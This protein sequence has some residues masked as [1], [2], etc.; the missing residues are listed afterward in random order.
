M[1]GS[2]TVYLTIIAII[3]ETIGFQNGTGAALTSAIQTTANTQQSVD[4]ITKSGPVKGEKLVTAIEGRTYYS[5]KGIPYAQPPIGPL[6]FLPP[7][8]TLPWTEPKIANQFGKACVQYDDSLKIIG[9]EN[10]LFLNVYVPSKKDNL[11]DR[12]VLVY[13]HG[14]NW[15]AGSGDDKFYGPDFLI[16]HGVILVTLN[17]R[18]GPMGFLSLGLGNYSGNQGLKDQQ[19]AVK[20][21]NENIAAFGGDPAK[22]TIFGHGTGSMSCE[23]HRFSPKSKGLFYQTIEMSGAWNYG[24]LFQSNNQLIPLTQVA[25]NNKQMDVISYLKTVDLSTL[26]TH[27]PPTSSR[28]INKVWGPVIEA[29]DDDQPFIWSTPTEQLLQPDFTSNVNI[30]TGFTSLEGLFV[31]DA[32]LLDPLSFIDPSAK[33]YIPFP[34]ENF[35]EFSTQTQRYDEAEIEIRQHYYPN[36]V[37]PTQKTVEANLKLISNVFQ[38]Y[39][40]D[41]RIKITAQQSNGNIFLYRFG[42]D[43]KFNYFKNLLGSSKNIPAGASHGDELCYTFKCNI[44]P[45]MYSDVKL[46]TPENGLL[47]VMPFFISN[48]ARFSNPNP[49]LYPNFQPCSSPDMQ[50]LDITNDGVEFVKQSP[51]NS[52]TEFWRKLMLKYSDLVNHNINV[53]LENVV[54]DILKVWA[55]DGT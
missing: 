22:I 3:G 45:D 32:K 44:V 51:W 24:K 21:V 20:W 48:F 11:P 29:A 38:N 16:N 37:T 28:A 7:L 49:I 10:C 43:T 8:P 19:L 46:G 42:L 53:P 27:F 4:V 50:Y 33:L 12:P 9:D 17:Y 31:A 13:F 41:K 36:G 35:Y 15:V 6:R 1:L 39:Q 40:M 52:D 54:N 2:W 5:Y 30:L 26:L 34:S 18:L 55:K 25:F 23:L 47:S 14:G